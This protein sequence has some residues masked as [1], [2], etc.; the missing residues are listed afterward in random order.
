MSDAVKVGFVPFSSAA[1]GTLV[2][3]TDDTL[4]FGA[5]TRKALG[6]AADM[7]KRAADRP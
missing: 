3:F 7:V 6:A 2:V 4:K 1:R 5:A